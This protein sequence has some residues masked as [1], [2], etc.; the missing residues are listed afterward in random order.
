MTEDI[1]SEWTGHDLLDVNGEKIGTVKDVR[2]GDATGG[3]TWLLVG[4]GLLGTKRV[5]VPAGDVRATEEALVVPFTKDRVKDSPGLHEH[6][7][8]TV[9]KERHICLYYGLRYE[10]TPPGAEEG[11]VAGGEEQPVSRSPEDRSPPLG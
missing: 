7:T 3:L 9:D 10:P 1:S 5:L 4:T 11:C 2:F 6:E 8:F